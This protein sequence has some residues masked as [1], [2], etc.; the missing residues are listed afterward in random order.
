[1]AMSG[2]SSSWASPTRHSSARTCCGGGRRA[3]PST[4]STPHPPPGGSR[5]RCMRPNPGGG[6]SRRRPGPPEVR[7]RLFA[8]M[9]EFDYNGHTISYDEYGEGDRPLI[10]VHG[11]LMSR[12]MFDRLGP[13]MAARGHRVITVDLLGHG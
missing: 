4:R 12:R 3:S 6:A 1:M 8:V 7:P 2:P 10:L 5:G 13:E 9:P 11:L